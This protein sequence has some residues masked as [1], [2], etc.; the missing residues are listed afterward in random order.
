M[1]E[2]FRWT[3]L[4][5]AI[6]FVIAMAAIIVSSHPSHQPTHQETAD[7]DHAEQTK[8]KKDVSLWDSWFPDPISVYTL[9]L[10]IFT[11]VL[12]FGGIYQLKFLVHAENIATT[13]ANAAKQS[14][15][16]AR[17]TLIAANR[18]WIWPE[19]SVGSDLVF[20]DAGATI[21]FRYVLR[22]AGNTPATNVELFPKF[23]AF[24]LG[25][26]QNPADVIPQTD[27]AEEG[28]VPGD[29]VGNR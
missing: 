2:M 26:A 29:G 12:A 23:M 16:T 22:N 25:G 8:T 15:D 20:S 6:V 19:F 9:F 18:S 28:R 24:N 1:L 13:S 14:A 7:K 21:T 11:G 17:D 3:A 10:V 4:I 27:A 5:A